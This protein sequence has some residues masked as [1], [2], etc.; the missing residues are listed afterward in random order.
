MPS[1]SA[2]PTES[3]RVVSFRAVSSAFATAARAP[4][5]GTRYASR[6]AARR[7]AAEGRSFEVAP[8]S[9][10]VRTVR[11]PGEDR[12]PPP[13]PLAAPLRLRTSALARSNFS[14]LD[15]MHSTQGALLAATRTRTRYSDSDVTMRNWRGWPPSGTTTL[16]VVRSMLVLGPSLLLRRYMM[17]TPGVLATSQRFCHRR[18]SPHHRLTYPSG[19]SG[20]SLYELAPNRRGSMRPYRLLRLESGAAGVEGP[21]A[22]ESGANPRNLSTTASSGSS[23][24]SVP[25][26]LGKSRAPWRFPETTASGTSR[27]E[28]RILRPIRLTCVPARRKPDVTCA[29]AAKPGMPEEGAS[30][31]APAPFEG[32]PG[33]RAGEGG[34]PMCRAR[35]RRRGGPRVR[36]QC[37]RPHVRW[38]PY[39]AGSIKTTTRG[40]W[41]HAATRENQQNRTRGSVCRPKFLDIN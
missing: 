15:L 10:E 16:A 9:A 18:K 23:P 24:A 32:E 3:D 28:P 17:R 13:P 11:A 30:G 29:T 37:E 41:D 38:R 6:S 2:H 25:D 4:S 40:A 8:S 7:V 21:G 33:G 1:F 19:G 34:G 5:S 31:S 20:V 12:P 27:A 36:T 39:T 22:V 35:R 26:V 14:A